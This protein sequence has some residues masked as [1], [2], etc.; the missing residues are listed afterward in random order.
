MVS[1]N[2]S[3]DK[4]FFWRVLKPSTT[5]PLTFFR[6]SS[7][8]DFGQRQVPSPGWSVPVTGQRALQHTVNSIY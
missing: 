5:T 4:I 8:L 6:F 1:G 2:F 3:I 7:I